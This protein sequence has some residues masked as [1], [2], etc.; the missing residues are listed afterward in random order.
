[1]TDKAPFMGVQ[2]NLSSFHAR[3]RSKHLWVSVLGAV[4][5]VPL[6]VLGLALEQTGWVTHLFMSTL[7]WCLL[8][9]FMVVRLIYKAAHIPAAEQKTVMLINTVLP[10]L[11][12]VLVFALLQQPYA[13]S[14]VVLAILTTTAWFGFSLRW[15]LKVDRLVL[16]AL[17]PKDVALLQTELGLDEAGLS[18]YVQVMVW[19]D[20]TEQVPECDGVLL[21]TQSCVDAVRQRQLMKLKQAHVRL[22]SVAV[23]GEML[24]GRIG[25]HVLNDVLWQPDG[26]PAYDLFKRYVDMGGV[27]LTA[28][29]WLSVGALVALVIKLDSPGSALFVQWRTGQH[30][31]PYRIYKFRTM[32]VQAAETAK[33]A[34]V[35]DSRVTRLGGFLRRSRLD[36]IPQLVNVLLGQMSLIGPRPEQRSFVNDFAVSIPS[37]PYRHLVRPGL[38]G[39][40]QVKQ[41]YAATEG[42]TSIKLSYDLYYVKHYSLALDLLIVVKTIRTVLTG[43]GAR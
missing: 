43:F 26:N 33:F 19:D 42:E 27:L 29:L 37:Y 8:P 18:R 15:L 28:P 17:E 39:W 21:S 10:F 36:E 34:Q 23:V 25:Q 16:L 40:A 20:E 31:K 14:A 5:F 24:S 1:M 41:G 38:T 11:L 32:V 2:N 3:R 35:N 6:Y 4:L 9:Y 30:G 7:L 22:Y 13:R 12:M